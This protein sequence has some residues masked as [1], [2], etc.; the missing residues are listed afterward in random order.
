MFEQAIEI[1]GHENQWQIGNAVGGLANVALT[2]GDAAAARRLGEESLSILRSLDDEHGVVHALCLLA[3]IDIVERQLDAAG[4]R[5]RKALTLSRAL[6]DPSCL[7]MGLVGFGC[8]AV[9]LHRSEQALRLFGAASAYGDASELDFIRRRLALDGHIQAACDM[10]DA[11][12]AQA[13]L[14]AGQT[15]RLEQAIDEALGMVEPAS[16]SI[17]GITGSRD[18]QP[19]THRPLPDVSDKL[20]PREREVARLLAVGRSNREIAQALVITEGT[21]EVHVK[22]S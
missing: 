16:E 20:T 8:L 22:R 13:A 7:I 15:L 9:A 3:D 18:H 17:G 4:A 10:L 6:A 21:A 1:F 19:L 11:P 2:E 12:S 5:L 14:V